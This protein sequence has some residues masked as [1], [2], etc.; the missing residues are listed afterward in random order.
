MLRIHKITGCFF[1]QQFLTLSL[2]HPTHTLFFNLPFL[3]VIA[4][5]ISQFAFSYDTL[6]ETNQPA[7]ESGRTLSSTSESADNADGNEGNVDNAEPDQSSV[8][9]SKSGLASRKGTEAVKKASSF[10]REYVDGVLGVLDMGDSVEQRQQAWRQQRRRAR[11]NE[12]QR[13]EWAPIIYCHIVVRA[14]WAALTWYI[15]SWY[16]LPR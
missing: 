3:I 4:I 13:G 7:Q 1:E 15:L 5:F 9:R 14:W 11:E 12:R 8:D 6:V 16:T 10:D 2:P